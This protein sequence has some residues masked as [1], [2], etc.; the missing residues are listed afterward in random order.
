MKNIIIFLSFILS[1]FL[2]TS[3]CNS[4]NKLVDND[5]AWKK[6]IIIWWA[7]SCPYCVQAMPEFK[8]KIYDV[9]KD[10]VDININSVN[11]QEFDVEIPQNL[12]TSNMPSFFEI[13][14]E[15]CNFVPSFAVLDE[16]NNVL[17]SS[18]WSE[19]SIEDIIEVIK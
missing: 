15:E 11:W 3:C 18:C 2:L 9:Y 6:Q 4:D 10:T 1:I 19:K 14:W 16:N 12:D 8:E 7:T 17:L 13:V 5:D